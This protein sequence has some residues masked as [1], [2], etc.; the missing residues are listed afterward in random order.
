[1][2]AYDACVPKTFRFHNED[3][4]V[5]QV[6]WFLGY[7]HV[8]SQARLD[9]RDAG[10]PTPAGLLYLPEANPISVFGDGTL[11][12]EVRR[13]AAR[14]QYASA[15]VRWGTCSYVQSS[16][17]FFL[18]MQTTSATRRCSP[19]SAA[20]S[21]CRGL[22]PAHYSVPSNCNA[23]RAHPRTGRSSAGQR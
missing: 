23:A 9:N 19:Y 14:L 4:I 22:N 18:D 21:V 12:S 2:A 1:M 17:P 3:D 7:T 6:P 5:A 10:D 15:C 11:S 16:T 8:K 13:V 20:A